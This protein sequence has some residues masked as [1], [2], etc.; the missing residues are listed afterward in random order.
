LPRSA[1]AL[2]VSNSA[3]QRAKRV[4]TENIVRHHRPIQPAA[5]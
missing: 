4:G 1:Q 5:E 3:A 2:A